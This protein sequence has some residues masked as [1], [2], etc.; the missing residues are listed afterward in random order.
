MLDDS[1][2]VELVSATNEANTLEVETV[3]PD[4]TP[5]DAVDVP[6]AAGAVLDRLAR[7][8]EEDEA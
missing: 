3:E 6:L 1:L 2:L 4:E 5:D 8:L 7:L